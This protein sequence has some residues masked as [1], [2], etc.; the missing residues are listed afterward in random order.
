MGTRLIGRPEKGKR[1]ASPRGVLRGVGQSL[2][3]LG[4]TLVPWLIPPAHAQTSRARALIIAPID[5]SRLVRLAGNT[6]PEASAYN[7]RGRVPDTLVMEHMQLLLRRPAEREAALRQ[8]IKEQHDRSSPNFHRWLTTA[9]LARRFGLGPQDLATVAGWLRQQGFTVNSV[10]PSTMVIDFSG[11]AGLVLGAFRCEIHFFDVRGA[12]HIANMSDPRLPAALAPAVVGIVSLHD[13]RPHTNFKSK[14]A[15]TYSSGGSTYYA[16][17]PADLAT[18]YDLGPLFAAG[19]SGQGQTIVVIEDTNVY[20]AADWTMFRSTFGLAAYTSGS[21]T[22]VHPAPASGKNNCTNP[23]VVAGNEAEAELDAEW[24]SAAAPSAAI[25]LASCQ[26]TSTT[27]GGLIALENLVNSGSPP[28]I[29]SISYGE[30]EADNGAAANAAYNTVYQQAVALGTSIFVAAGDE[31]AASCDA[32]QIRSTHGIGVSGFASTPYDVAVGGTDFGDTYAGT[33]GA[34]WSS[35]NGGNFGSAVSYVPEIP[36]NDS[37][38]SS[39]I[40]TVEGYAAT[41]G[42]SGF[43]NSTAGIDY[44]LTTV[45]GGGGPSGCATGA[46]SAAGVVGGTCQGYLK[47][48]WQSVIGNP[49]DGVRDIPDVS[50]FAANG[51]WG[52]YYVYCDSDTSDHGAACTGAPSGWSKAGGTSF[53]SPI[54]AGIQALVNQKTASLQG[55]PNYVYYALAKGEY[56]SGLACNS[57]SG[58][59]VSGGC[60]FYDV[61]L[62]DMDIN[63]QGANDCYDPSGSNGVLSTNSSAYSTAYGAGPGWDFATGIGTINAYNLVSYW[64]SSDLSLS[65]GGSVTPTGLL[66]YSWTIANDGP[67]AATGV[68][69]T[70]VLP[71]GLTLA[72]GSSSAGC[73]Q[74]GQQVT[75]TVGSLANGSSAPLT[76]VIQ[77]GT[78]QTVNLTFTATSNNSDLD[79]SEGVM[80]IYLILPPAAETDVPLPLWAEVTFGSL[81]MMVA[82][83]SRKNRASTRLP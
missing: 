48:S 30:C 18:I 35:T 28:A 41:Y 9:Q 83:R 36:W 57:T 27:F 67:Q 49:S 69:L 79:P 10:Y 43:C 65:G 5:E 22:Q 24:A 58:N 39:L 20:S 6:R 11:S 52:H 34:Y 51:T 64:N 74:A 46:P 19:I 80:S 59:A 13:F 50:L 53:A 12:R 82:I 37:C 45:S 60:V 4:L 56:A 7:D 25:E 71:A 66:S 40:A 8:F 47:P 62:G 68:V 44:F 21:F 76:I 23:G 61:T 38:A 81:L 16:V 33:S 26:D 75:C 55:N 2:L 72:T 42:A 1:R 70:T 29:V 15:Y 63:C 14:S 31:G 17:V 77:P 73:A 3:A 54:M 32:N 78:A